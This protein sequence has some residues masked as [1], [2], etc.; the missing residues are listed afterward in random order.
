MSNDNTLLYN[1]YR[2][3]SLTTIIGHSATVKD[4][5][6]RSKNNT[7]PRVMLFS[8]ITGI[9]KTTF[10]RI[11]SKNIICNDR[12]ENGNSCNV[13]NICKTIDNE[14]ISNFYF[15]I[16]A[17]S[18]N[19]DEVRTLI[20]NAE[21]KSFSN[22]KAKIFVIDEV[23][24]MKK[25]QAALNALLKPIEKEYKNVY[26]I[27]GTMDDKQVPKAILNRCTVYKLKPHTLEDISKQLYS[28]CNLENVKIETEEQANV[29]VTLAENSYGSLRQAISYLERVINS[30][31]WTTKEVNKELGLVSAS[32][33]NQKI[34]SL[35]K[36]RSDAFEIV[37]S[38][39][40]INTIRYMFGAMY[41]KL[42]DV[43][44]EGW[45]LEKLTG[46]DRSITIKQV[47][48]ALNKLFDL[49]KYPYINQEIIDFTLVDIF[50]WNKNYQQ[51]LVDKALARKESKELIK[52]LSE[53]IQQ[54]QIKRRGQA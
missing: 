15:E 43:P 23:Q 42:S 29:L 54:P 5:Q 18:L 35:F 4:L 11:I 12:D 9:G 49:N 30:E 27:F 21:V 20:E 25:S 14:K 37:Y 17:S 33:L 41:K 47:E 34:N 6:K 16:N 50:N 53:E 44:V 52:A 39:D 19:I 22:A 46:I 32:E 3:N 48:H 51:E 28:I 1:K 2:P 38:E 13:C 26:F 8:G 40:L 7:L 24:E 31:L 45:Q 10:F 36:G